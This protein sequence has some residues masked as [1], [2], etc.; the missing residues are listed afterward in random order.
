MCL[1]VV[2]PRS[3]PS[4]L[5]VTNL[6]DQDLHSRARTHFSPNFGSKSLKEMRAGMMTFGARLDSDGGSVPVEG[7]G[8]CD[9]DSMVGGRRIALLGKRQRLD[10]G[11]QKDDKA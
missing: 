9:D 1:N 3:R 4:S 8:Y 7:Q 11:D 5:L 2:G 6:V 10:D